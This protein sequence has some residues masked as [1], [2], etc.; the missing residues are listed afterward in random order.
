MTDLIV[1]ME[2]DITFS[3][4]VVSSEVLLFSPGYIHVRTITHNQVTAFA[5]KAVRYDAPVRRNILPGE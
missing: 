1:R 3:M 5:V 2:N 4:T